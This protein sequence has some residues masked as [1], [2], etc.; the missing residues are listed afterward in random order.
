[1][2]TSES[3]QLRLGVTVPDPERRRLT[4]KVFKAAELLIGK[5]P[6]LKK[7]F[8]L[9]FGISSLCLFNLVC[10]FL[11]LAAV[12]KK[13]KGK[14]KRKRTSKG[15]TN[16]KGQGKGKGQGCNHLDK[17]NT[18][19]H[20]VAVPGTSHSSDVTST[21]HSRTKAEMVSRGWPKPQPMQARSLPTL[22]F[23]S[24]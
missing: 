7:G 3:A 24:Q 20:L 16:G 22:G 19:L 10:F 18:F 4:I 13:G 9:Y 5:G 17:T 21:H 2:S 14:G 15:Q 11:L 12:S 1:M 23:F 6:R 8:R